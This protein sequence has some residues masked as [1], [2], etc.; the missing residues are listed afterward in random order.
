[1]NDRLDL[2]PRPPHSP[3]LYGN[4]DVSGTRSR[5]EFKGNTTPEW[6]VMRLRKIAMVVAARTHS[7][8]IPYSTITKTLGISRD[9]A[10]RYFK[11]GKNRL[12]RMSRV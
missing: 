10:H 5:G 6:K 12:A 3:R 8:P 2:D 1:M 7:P 11:I 9:C 4:G